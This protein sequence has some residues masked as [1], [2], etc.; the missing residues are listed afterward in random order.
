MIFKHLVPLNIFGVT[1]IANANAVSPVGSFVVDD[2]QRNIYAQ[3]TAGTYV[4]VGYITATSDGS[5]GISQLARGLDACY[6][7]AQSL[8]GFGAGVS[9]IAPFGP[10]LVVTYPA[11]N[12]LWNGSMQS[13]TAGSFT[14][15]SI[16]DGTYSF[17][18]GYQWGLTQFQVVAPNISYPTGFIELC[19][20]TVSGLSA[21]LAP[22]RINTMFMK[23]YGIPQPLSTSSTNGI[24]ASTSTGVM[25][26]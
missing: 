10:T 13:I 18:V 25:P 19:Q 3:T 17:G 15:P 9:Q 22:A 5:G 26:W 21:A 1:P 20:V 11:L 2:V 4:A 6:N 24:P 8:T 12:I 23:K 16:T 7:S 14:K